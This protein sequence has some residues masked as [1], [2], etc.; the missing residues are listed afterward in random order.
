MEKANEISIP[1]NDRTTVTGSLKIPI[2]SNKLVI[3]SHGSGSSRHSPRNQFV[4]DILNINKISTL[5]T[6]LLTPEEDNDYENRFNIDLLTHRLMTITR[7]VTQLDS[8]SNMNIGYFGAST[9]AAS[10]LR[11]AAQLRDTIKAVVSRGGRADLADGDLV[12]VRAPTLLIVGSLDKPVL[13]MNQYAYDLLNCTKE[14]KII[15]GATHL[16]EESGKLEEVAISATR[17]FEKHLN[18]VF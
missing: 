3:F 10:A 11:A 14:I 6:D 16:F 17:W 8:C 15:Y 1:I 5:L 4:A 7:Y 18:Y 2:N 9:G 13:A 12:Y